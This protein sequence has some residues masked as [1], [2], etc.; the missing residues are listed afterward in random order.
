MDRCSRQ[1]RRRVEQGFDSDGFDIAACGRFCFRGAIGAVAEHRK[2]R[3]ID[4]GARK[5]AYYVEGTPYEMG[6]LMGMMAEPEIDRM[7]S[8]YID[9]MVRAMLHGARGHQ[10]EANEAGESLGLPLIPMHATLVNTVYKRLRRRGVLDA[11]PVRYHQE[12]DGMV[13]GC[14]AAAAF[15][16]RK[17]SVTP[18]EL[19]VL[20]VGVD[21]LFAVFQSGKLL[22]LLFPGVTPHHLGSPMWCNGFALLGSAKTGGVLMGRDFMFPTG[23]V[24]QDLAT[25]IIR[26]PQAPPGDALC[27]TVSVAAPGFVGGMTAMNAHGVAAGVDVSPGGNCDPSDPGLNSLLLVRHA[28]ESGAN[29]TQAVARIVDAHRGVSWCYLVA[30]G[31][32]GR[33]QAYVVEAG[34]STAP[35]PSVSYIS[36]L[37]NSDPQLRRLLPRRPFLLDHP[38]GDVRQGAMVRSAD[39]IDGLDDYIGTFNDAL[40]RHFPGKTLHADA[41]AERGY[42]NR[43]TGCRTPTSPEDPFEHNCPGNYYFAPQRGRAGEVL[44]LANHF[45]HP[46]MRIAAMKPWTNRVY[47]SWLTDDSQWRYDDLNRRILEALDGGRIDRARARELIDFLAPTGDTPCYYGRENPRSRDGKAIAISGAVSVLDLGARDIETH[48]GYYPDKWVRIRLGGYVDL[49]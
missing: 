8:Q 11:V 27:P 30:D 29:G 43:T 4:T 36:S 34:A 48:Y 10:D 35:M 49:P 15:A 23:E 40:W 17:T 28:V 20:N 3:N 44:L 46:E 5:R 31:G 32:D 33:E 14:R 45:L 38:T 25:M 42:I 16:R 47:G 13:D 18:E 6:Y 26:N 9:G 41:F 24:F 12:I 19:W 37:R 21:F 39:G 22:N 1:R 7:T 2:A